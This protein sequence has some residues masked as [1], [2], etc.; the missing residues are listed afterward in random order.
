MP[1]SSDY[2]IGQPLVNY[3]T[4]IHEDIVGSWNLA[5]EDKVRLVF[6]LS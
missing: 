3:V 4:V 6:R 5:H 1:C 2:F